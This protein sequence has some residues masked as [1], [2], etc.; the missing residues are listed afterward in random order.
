MKKIILSLI[1]ISIALV[2]CD[3]Q[4]MNEESIDSE[5]LMVAE[6]AQPV[7]SADLSVEET[8]I[9]VET[10]PLDVVI[11]PAEPVDREGFVYE[12]NKEFNFELTTLHVDDITLCLHAYEPY[13]FTMHYTITN[14]TNDEVHWS[15]HKRGNICGTFYAK[16]YDRVSTDSARELGGNTHWTEGNLE[17]DFYTGWYV[18]G[19][20]KLHAV[21]NFLLDSYVPVKDSDFYQD[22]VL[23]KNEP[24]KLV[25][26]YIENGNYYSYEI[27]LN[28]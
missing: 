4:N 13:K 6:I 17:D 21:A 14:K 2:G 12:I 26:D 3:Y 10:E 27:L 19:N 1:I 22:I 7:A 8:A 9:P 24:M 11:P 16:P 18:A 20:E 25:M 28:Q 15:F 23:L 5:K